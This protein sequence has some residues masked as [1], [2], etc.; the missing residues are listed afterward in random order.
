MRTLVSQSFR[1]FILKMYP[2]L[3]DRPE[4]RRFF[5]YLCFGTF[6][7]QDTHQLVMP[8]R[9]IAEEF[10][11]VPYNSHFKGADKLEEFRGLVLPGLRWSE[12]SHFG[13]RGYN[14]K[15]RRILD[16]GFDAEMLSALQSEQLSPAQDQIDLVSGEPFPASRRSRQTVEATAQ[17]Q[18]QLATQPLNPTQQKILD[19]LGGLNAGHLFLRHLGKNEAAVQAALNDLPPPVQEMQRRILASVRQNPNLYYAPSPKGHP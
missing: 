14:G 4:F 1:Q 11:Q 19:Y 15:A 2:A 18:Q 8:T 9:V 12:Y 10:Y 17:Y 7:D 16:L 13:G 6:F 5:Q 3:Q